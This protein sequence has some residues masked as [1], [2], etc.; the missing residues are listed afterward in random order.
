MNNELLSIVSY[1]ERDRGVNREIIIQRSVGDSAGPPARVWRSQR[2]RVE[3]ARKTWHQS[4]DTVVVSDEETGLGL[5]RCARRTCT[6][7]MRSSATRCRSSAARQAGAYRRAD[8]A[9]DDL[10]EI[11][12]AERKNVYDEYKD[13]FGDV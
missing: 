7:A 13:R 9:P 8:G 3:I 1:L 6:I 12:E 4:V 2:M 10:A 11:R 5:F